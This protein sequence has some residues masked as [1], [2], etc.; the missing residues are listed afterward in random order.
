MDAFRVTGRRPLPAGAVSHDWLENRLIGSAQLAG[1]YVFKSVL[2]ALAGLFHVR[3]SLISLTLGLELFVVGHITDF[4][5]RLALGF[6]GCILDLVRTTPDGS[7]FFPAGYR[8]FTQRG[9]L[10][11]PRLAAVNR[12]P[13]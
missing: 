8:R 7:P 4:L 5:L 10:S 11:W 12:W 13:L 9:N 6:F 1:T 2:D 3:F